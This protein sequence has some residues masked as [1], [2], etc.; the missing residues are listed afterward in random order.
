MSY[1]LEELEIYQLSLSLADE[2]WNEVRLWD[3]FNKDTIGKQII[4]SSD[5]IAANI[6][7]G[8]GRYFYKEN[9]QFCFFSRG[10]LLET[11][12]WLLK[13]RNRKL[14]DEVK[15]NSYINTLETIHK[16][17]NSYI[18]FIGKEEKNKPMTNDQ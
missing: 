12:T 8:Y 13:S 9:K 16:K 7:E 10:S 11:K 17:L 1:T 3:Y 6:A 2:I 14:I 4:R 15:Y 18:K 5:S